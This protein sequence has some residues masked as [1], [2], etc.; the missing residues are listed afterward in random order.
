[1]CLNT[2][3]Y[4]IKIVFIKDNTTNDSAVEVSLEINFEVIFFSYSLVG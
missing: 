1:M 3:V 2:R 4:Q